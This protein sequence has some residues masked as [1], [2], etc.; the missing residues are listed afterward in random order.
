MLV[1]EVGVGVEFVNEM[2]K[3]IRKVETRL[4]ECEVAC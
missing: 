3:W 2:L 4:V 1:L